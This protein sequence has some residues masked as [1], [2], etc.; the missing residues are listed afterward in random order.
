MSTLATVIVPTLAI[1]ACDSLPAPCA[2]C[3]A[4]PGTRPAAHH[5]VVNGQRYD[6]ALLAWL[7]AQPV[8]VTRLQQGSAPLA[9]LEGRRLVETGYFGYLD[10]DDE[11]LPG[12]L[13]ERLSALQ[14]DPD[15]DLVVCNGWRARDGHDEPAFNYLAESPAD[16]L[17][18]LLRE[19]WLASCG[20]LF[21]TATVDVSYFEDPMPYLE[22]TWLAWRLAVD[23]R[24]IR[25]SET[26]GFRI[27][28]TGGSASKSTEYADA[29]IELYERMLADAPPSDVARMVGTDTGGDLIFWRSW[30][31]RYDVTKAEG[32]PRGQGVDL[33]RH[34]C[35]E[36]ASRRGG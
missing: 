10:D 27:H 4:R 32:M 7:E 25:V 3:G 30:V 34:G 12:S 26:P 6:P 18:A 23:G 29:Q 22:W 11:Y 16:P 19:N 15:S 17:R 24:R 28:D 9:Q 33:G 13:D 1:E 14:S 21:R 20:V 5:V 36:A 31:F 35:P 2:A 8:T